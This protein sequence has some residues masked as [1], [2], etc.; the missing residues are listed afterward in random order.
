VTPREQD[1]AFVLESVPGVL[2]VHSLAKAGVDLDFA[3]RLG[4]GTGKLAAAHYALLRVLK[5]EECHRVLFFETRLPPRLER[6]ATPIEISAAEREASRARVPERGREDPAP[7]K[8][9]RSGAQFAAL[10]V[11]RTGDVH[12]SV[13]RALGVAAH[14]VVERDPRAGAE[15]ARTEEFDVLICASSVAF[16]RLG[17][18]ETVYRQ[19]P[20]LVPRVILIAEPGERDLVIA[21]LEQSGRYNTCLTTPVDPALILEIARTGYFSEPSPAAPAPRKP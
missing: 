7:P 10:L 18:L 9:V 4:H 13:V 11:G 19:D 12:H 6:A 15:R 16:G 14:R 1:V 8:R 3:V 20:F 2:G 17:F 21:R 5:R